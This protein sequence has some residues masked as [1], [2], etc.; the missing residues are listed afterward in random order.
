[1]PKL[2]LDTNVLISALHFGGRPREL[3]DLA[4]QGQIELVLSPFILGETEKV[5]RD[6]LHWDDWMLTLTL[7]K[8]RHMATVVEPRHTIT[9]IKA[10]DA[11][12]RILECAEAG[13]ADFL[14]TGD[15]KHILP[16]KEY[17]GIRI[18]SPA[19]FLKSFVREK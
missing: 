4:R 6:K 19:E 3:L 9:I 12:N 14:I 15:K 1:M 8:V 16:L 17:Q 7:S 5:L 18:L 13:G 2:V 10:K 11:D